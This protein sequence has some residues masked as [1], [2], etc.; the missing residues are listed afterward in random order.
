MALEEEAHREPAIITI[1]V[2]AS[3]LS[4]FG[5]GAAF[6]G[7]IAGIVSSMLLNW[8]QRELAVVTG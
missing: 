7:L 6:W 3:G 8:R 4:L 5:I 1:L 2:S